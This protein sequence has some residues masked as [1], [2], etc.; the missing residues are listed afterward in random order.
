MR[1]RTFTSS[2]GRRPVVAGFTLVELLVVIG[3]IALLISILLPSLN[4]ARE[5]ANRMKC[6]SNL[7]QIALSAI[8]YANTNRGKFPRTYYDP[9]KGLSNDCKGAINDTPAEN[10]FSLSD[11]AGPVPPNSA[12][13]SLFLLARMGDLP[14]ASFLC[15]SFSGSEPFTIEANK[16]SNF[17]K[18]YRQSCSYSYSGPFPRLATA[19][20]G[21]KFDTTLSPDWPLASDLNPGSGGAVMMD[22]VTDTQDARA[23]AYTDPPKVMARGNSNNHKAEGQQV[24]YVDAHVEWHTSPF[25][26]V[27]APG[28]VWNDNIC[29][30]QSSVDPV[31]GKGGNINGRPWNRWDTSMS[32]SD[33]AN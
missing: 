15:P 10:P 32:P 24:A 31:T 29:T 4:R 14:P 33:G 5:V 26:G 9:A 7:R 20:A 8:M 12:A 25:A 21:W 19:N 1:E 16:Y 18:P 11:P 3:I 2:R 22:G 6:A 23:V 17:H 30:G 13:A 27:K 28:N